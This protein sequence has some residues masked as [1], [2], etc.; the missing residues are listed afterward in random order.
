MVNVINLPGPSMYWNTK[1]VFACL[2]LSV[3]FLFPISVLL[4]ILPV[5]WNILLS[6]Y[7]QWSRL[8]VKKWNTKIEKRRNVVKFFIWAPTFLT[9]LFC[10]HFLSL[11]NLPAN[12]KMA[13]SLKFHHCYGVML[14]ILQ[15][16]STHLERSVVQNW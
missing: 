6:C 3:L 10:Q 4:F 13:E 16:I 12:S 15:P 14:M 2:P 8:S 9:I 1:E 11:Y 7:L 5:K